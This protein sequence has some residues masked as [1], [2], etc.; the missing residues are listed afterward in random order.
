MLGALALGG[1]VYFLYRRK[2][3][4]KGPDEY[5]V[6][7]SNEKRSIFGSGRSADRNGFTARGG[8]ST[9]QQ[10]GIFA[11]CDGESVAVEVVLAT[12]AG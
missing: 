8:A 2:R 6:Y 7:A 12:R 11:V 5:G 3:P 4:S 10:G 1:L 9:D